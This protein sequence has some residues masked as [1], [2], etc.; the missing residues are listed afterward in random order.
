MLYK[1][2]KICIADTECARPGQWLILTLL[3]IGLA[4]QT[5]VQ[6]ARYWPSKLREEILSMQD[7]RIEAALS[8]ANSVFNP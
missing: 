7:P 4:S 6:Q 8:N 1:T 2:L 3:N 5:R